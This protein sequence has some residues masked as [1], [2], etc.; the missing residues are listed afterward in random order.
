MLKGKT[1]FITGGAGFIGTA[2]IRCIIE[3]NRVIVY[4]NL[5]RNS[6]VG[7]GLCTHPNLTIIQGDVLNYDHLK[8]SIPQSVDVV[9]HM[10]AI[11]GIDTVI[12]DPVKTLEVNA[13]GSYHLLKALMEL[14]LV[15][16]IQRF[17]YF[18]TSEVF[19]IEA[20]RVSESSPTNLQPVGEARWTYA[21]SKL[22]GEH[23]T[24]SY[25]KQ[26]G[27]RA[28]TIRPF[29]VY[30][31][32]QVGEG[33]IHQFVIRAIR[34]EPLIIHGEGDQ[35]RSWCYID[36]MVD[37][38]LLCLEKESAI[39]QVFNVGNPRGTITILRL[40]EK[41]VQLSGSSSRIVHVPKPYVD[42]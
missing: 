19:G 37:G 34:G 5:S 16:R 10:A 40:A 8:S 25:Y 3:E 14:G 4:D 15:Q 27:L 6:L 17:V 35:I 42:V 39:G 21:V 26:F 31:P 36:D 29:N 1:F 9:L 13:I 41:I 24:H 32:G 11:A 28:V 2:L 18:S 38:I 20:F 23:L 7:S 30:G 12:K 33:A 22:M